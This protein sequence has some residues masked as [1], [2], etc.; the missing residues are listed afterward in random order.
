MIPANSYNLER[1][2]CLDTKQAMGGGK[3]QLKIQ[4]L[5]ELFFNIG[6]FVVLICSSSSTDLIIRQDIEM[7]YLIKFS[8]PKGTSK[9]LIEKKF[10]IIL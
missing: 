9:K 1:F 7:K 2:R 10:L 5:H 3:I 8:P 6:D 4:L